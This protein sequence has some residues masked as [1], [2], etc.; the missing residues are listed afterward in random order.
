[1]HDKHWSH[2]VSEKNLNSP[3]TTTISPEMCFPFGGLPPQAA[4]GLLRGKKESEGRGAGRG[5][6]YLN[7]LVAMKA[8]KA[9]WR[10]MDGVSGEK[11]REEG[12]NGVES[13]CRQIVGLD[14]GL[15]GPYKP[16]NLPDHHVC[17]CVHTY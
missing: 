11:S 10:W 5:L 17:V 9:C 15:N 12:V 4:A 13:S 8:A 6:I 2:K 16:H 7:N 1:M 14:N 3:P